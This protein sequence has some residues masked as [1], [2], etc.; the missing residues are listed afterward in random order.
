MDA[1]WRILT[2]RK[3]RKNLLT[4]GSS[5]EDPHLRILTWGSSVEGFQ[6][7]IRT[8]GSTLKDPFEDPCKHSVSNLFFFCA[9][10]QTPGLPYILLM[11]CS[12]SVAFEGG[13]IGYS[14]GCHQNPFFSV[15]PCS[16]HGV[17]LR[18]VLHGLIILVNPAKCVFSHKY[19]YI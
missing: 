19:P 2:Q 4:Q 14:C 16:L 6:S 5:F 11:I 18:I 12:T 13:Q 3:K 17:N 1:R 15:S 10:I 9:K 7:R 8:Q